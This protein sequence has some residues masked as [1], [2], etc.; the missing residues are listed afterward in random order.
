MVRSPPA[1]SYTDQQQRMGRR[2]KFISIRFA[3]LL[4]NS[5]LLYPHPSNGPHASRVGL[6]TATLIVLFPGLSGC[7]VVG[8]SNTYTLLRQSHEKALLAA[9]CERFS[10]FRGQFPTLSACNVMNQI[11]LIR[12]A[13][14]GGTD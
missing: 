9:C 6:R 4:N 14:S 7:M 13:A 5:A 8:L 2:F 11:D 10:F 1:P 12:L 3:Y